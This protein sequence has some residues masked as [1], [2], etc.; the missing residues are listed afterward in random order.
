MCLAQC[1]AVVG[2]HSVYICALPVKREFLW[3][4][5]IEWTENMNLIL[6]Q[7]VYLIHKKAIK[8]ILLTPIKRIEHGGSEM[9]CNL[10]RVA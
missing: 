1:L 8:H 9:L 3:F 4:F 10:S 7:M 5:L 2:I 6:V